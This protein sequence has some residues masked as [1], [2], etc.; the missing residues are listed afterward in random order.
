MSNNTITTNSNNIFIKASEVA[1][2]MDVSRAYAYRI[3]KQLNEELSAK[4]I[5]TVDG[6]TNRKYFY[7]RFY[8]TVSA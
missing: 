2:V 1:T 6:R 5:L 7:E 4:G 8:G 3:V